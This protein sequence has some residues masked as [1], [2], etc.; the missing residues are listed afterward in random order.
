MQIE[1]YGKTDVGKKR[2]KNEDSFLTDEKL[3]LYVVADGMG[4]HLGGGY[5][6]KM[7]VETVE[8]TLQELDEDPNAT[9]QETTIPLK[10]GDFKGYL[11]HA[12]MTASRRIYE[13]SVKDKKLQGMGT[14][15]VVLTFRNNRAYI[16]NVGD[17]RGY[18]FRNGKLTQVTADHSLVAE[19]IRAGILKPEEAKEHRLKNVITRSVGFQNDVEVDTKAQEVKEGD[20]FL[21]CSDGLYNL[22]EDTEISDIVSHNS[23]K[24][25]CSHLIDI[26]NSRGGDDNITVVIAKVIELNKR[27]EEEEE[28]ETQQL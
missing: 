1:Y 7:A 10:P 22:V 11:Q 25:A 19:Q 23:L 6:S 12:L 16:A 21:L 14:T 3:Q 26:A 13:K 24:D 15:C 4:G 5:A 18:F 28:E 8:E 27:G 9:L 20:T 2:E 17:S